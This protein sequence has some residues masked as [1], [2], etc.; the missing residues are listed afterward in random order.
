MLSRQAGGPSPRPGKSLPAVLADGYAVTEVTRGETGMSRLVVT[1]VLS[2]SV[3]LPA[4][5]DGHDPIVASLAKAGRPASDLELDPRRRPDAVLAFFGIEPGMTV[6]ELFAGGGYYTE[7]LSG[8]V[9]EGG[10]VWAH[11]NAPYIAYTREGLDKRLRTGRLANVKPLRAENNELDLPE[12]TFD[13]ALFALAYHDVYYVDEKNGWAEIDGPAM[14]AEIFRAMK[15]G[16]VLGVID[17][18]AA[19]G[20][21]PK[22]GGT[23]HRID[24]VL[25]RGDLEAAGFVYEGEIDVLR[26]PADDHTL[27][28]NDPA[29][30][31]QTDRVVYRFVVP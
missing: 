17:H 6:F 4:L 11:N 16:G 9:G 20:A 22:T 13:A 12:A 30:K 21:P 26:N 3:S 5:A 29:I 2:L 23:L 1:F 27:P 15:P 7:I 25:L 14:L 10:E 28:I 31:R 18:V 24:P 8:I 19:A